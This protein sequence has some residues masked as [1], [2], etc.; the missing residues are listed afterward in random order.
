MRENNATVKVSYHVIMRAGL[1]LFS[2]QLIAGTNEPP[3][4]VVGDSKS[5]VT[6]L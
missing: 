3:N 5:S 4:S 2:K 1:S 6:P